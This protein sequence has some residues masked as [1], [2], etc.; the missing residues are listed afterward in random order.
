MI[1]VMLMRRFRENFS[2]IQ[3][4]LGVLLKGNDWNANLWQRGV[5]SRQTGCRQAS[6]ARQRV[7]L[8]YFIHF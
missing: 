5:R 8:T 4:Q 3:V 7:A 1:V 6:T 2:Q